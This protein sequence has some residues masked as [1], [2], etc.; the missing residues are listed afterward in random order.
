MTELESNWQEI[1]EFYNNS[2][3]N[4]R[5]IHS[6]AQSAGLNWYANRPAEAASEY[7]SKTWHQLTH[8]AS[9]GPKKVT[10]LVSILEAAMHKSVPSNPAHTANQQETTRA[11]AQNKKPTP[12]PEMANFGTPAWVNQNWPE[13]R[14]SLEKTSLFTQLISDLGLKFGIHWGS[15]QPTALKDVFDYESA[16]HF[17]NET[18]GVGKTKAPV[19]AEII[20][21]AWSKADASAPPTL[22]QDPHEEAKL[23]LEEQSGKGASL[24]GKILFI[25]D[26]S[27]CEEIEAEVLSL[28]F[29]LENGSTMTLE[30]VGKTKQQTRQNIDLI[31]KKG[32]KK[33]AGNA[34]ISA[35]LTQLLD[36]EW[37]DILNRL[38][39]SAKNSILPQKP[40]IKLLYA[41][42]RFLI[43]ALHGKLPS[44]LEAHEASG[45]ITQVDQ[46]WWIGETL[47]QGHDEV[48]DQA[49]TL[50][51]ENG[52]LLPIGVLK[53]KLS[54]SDNSLEKLKAVGIYLLDGY[55]FRE[56][57]TNMLSRCLLLLKTAAS[58]RKFIWSATDLHQAANE[59]APKRA[60]ALRLINRDIAAI[61]GAG[62]NPEGPL[63][64]VNPVAAK[65]AGLL[66]S[67]ELPQNAFSRNQSPI[68]HWDQGK[69]DSSV[70]EY[71]EGV[72][73]QE[74]FLSFAQLEARYNED[75]IGSPNS[76]IPTLYFRPQFVRYAPGFIGIAGLTLEK[77]YIKAL[78]NESSLKQYV[79][80]KK[81]GGLTELFPFWNAAM[82]YHWCLW[83]KNHVS[84]SLFHSL[85][86][87]CTPE[88]WNVDQETTSTSLAD[89]SRLADF[90]LPVPEANGKAAMS[91]FKCLYP[92]VHL[93]AERKELGIATIETCFTW[94]AGHIPAAPDTLQLLGKLGVVE[95]Q[96][97]MREPW[98]IGPRCL[99][100]L[101]SMSQLL[102]E[103]PKNHE[104]RW[105]D[106]LNAGFFV[107]SCEKIR[108]GES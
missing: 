96:P 37:P 19:L 18:K 12:S 25:I 73:K 82:E 75:G 65:V 21:K 84:D 36:R 105:Q 55:A 4:Q 78:L 7:T 97:N 11:D 15:K 22:A 62:I 46:G 47:D 91:D 35:Y 41:E 106:F 90:K 77:P 72:L 30:A 87:I 85:L 50:L 8:L 68:T 14:A 70:A 54:C 107:N 3:L 103:H 86:D 23:L 26:Q 6:L 94:N 56:K 98:P 100:W 67:I 10:V 13:L 89:K 99:E 104:A 16:D 39:H 43:T 79:Y 102:F 69:K 88:E 76:L 74:K 1:R 9:F 42:Q 28:L 93:A 33:L 52:G 48:G 31:K 29:G 45:A 58:H 38:S 108:T 64:V 17:I 44:A 27:N 81:L 24:S 32:L 49:K 40:P 61:P 63:I 20:T 66:D 60:G 57:P 92:L 101:I 59:I 53:E 83:A 2:E 95:S 51:Q 34:L 5:S 71:I 80:A